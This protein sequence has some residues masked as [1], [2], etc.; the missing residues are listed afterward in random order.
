MTAATLTQTLDEKLREEARKGMSSREEAMAEGRAKLRDFAVVLR[1]PGA[2]YALSPASR[3]TPTF[4]VGDAPNFPFASVRLPETPGNGHLSP[5]GANDFWAHMKDASQRQ[6]PASRDAATGRAA[7]AVSNDYSRQLGVVRSPTESAKA[8][9]LH[10]VRAQATFAAR[11]IGSKLGLGPVPSS[12]IGYSLERALEKEGF[13]VFVNH[14]VDKSVDMFKAT[15]SSAATATG[16]RHQAESTLNKSMQWLATHGVTPEAFKS[17]LTKHAGAI[18]AVASISQHPEVM[19]R[20]AHIIAQSPKGLD[21][22]MNIAKDSELRKAVGTMTLAAGESLAFVHKGAGSAAI[23]AGS[24][25]RGDSLADTGRHAFRAALSVL[26]GAAGGVVVGAG[27]MGFGSVAGAVAGAYAGSAA[28]DKL[29]GMY[30]Q[31]FNNGRTPDPVRVAQADVDQSKAVLADRARDGVQ[32]GAQAAGGRV[33][34]QA[35]ERVM[36]FKP[37]A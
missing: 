20:A 32:A 11:E 37:S 7:Q 17:A 10:E 4:K 26:G 21:M 27:S 33:Q 13:K 29:I 23:L 25:M 30:D 1:D 8:Q 9:L 36:Q 2:P 22:A 24:A 35:H 12:I 15:A 34:E 31:H 3:I 16:V 6:D 19:Q 28:A 5:T 18:T 14:A